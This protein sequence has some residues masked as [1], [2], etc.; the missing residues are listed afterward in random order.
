MATL[1]VTQDR[2]RTDV[3][4]WLIA[5]TV[6]LATFMEVLDTSVANVALPHIAG[7]LS[8]GVDEST[9]V[10]TSYLVS[11][12]IVLPLTGWLSNVFGRKQFY[13]AC[14]AIFTISSFLCGLAPSLGALVFFR[15]IQGAGGGGLQPISQAILVDSFPREKQGMAMAIYGMGVVVAP[16]IGPTLG[17]WITDNFTWR[18]I[19]FI[20]IPIGILSILLTTLLITNPPYA[21]K[22]RLRIDFIGI[23]L[24]SV[25]VGF[26]QIVL[27]KGQ[28]DDWFGSN[29]IVWATVIAL[30][31][32]VGVIVWELKQ[33]DPI[34]DLHLLKERNF[35]VAVF[36]MYILGFV[37][38][39]TTVL[40]PILLQTL[41]G[42][43]AMQSGLVLLPGG[44]LMMVAMP[45]VGWAL[46]KFEARWLVVIGLTITASG[47]FMM[48]SH[49]DLQM[50]EKTP[51]L[52]WIVSRFGVAFL[53]VPIN[54]I[55]FYYVLP[56]KINDATGLINLA[57]NIG[58]SMGISFVT[59]LLDR[60]AQSNQ[61]ILAAHI[62]GTNYQYQ[63][64]IQ[65]MVQHF[66]QAG[67]SAAAALQLA[68]RTFYATLQGQAM[69]LS[70]LRDFRIMGWISLGMIPFMFILKRARPGRRRAT[71]IH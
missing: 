71:P 26:L 23:G 70:F 55:A 41:L 53:F 42:Y 29:F 20:N 47:L 63:A 1:S 11:N 14:V 59:T 35:A 58:G 18:W 54:V 6:M 43:T 50:G 15:V 10:L 34:I 68:Q 25:G 39:G 7:S 13:M 64:A 33:K 9:W 37:L 28:R 3:N 52:V 2:P 56:Q 27:D 12:A 40:L 30:I 61:S 36:T 32:I 21:I 62:T 31:G 8:A 4:P 49:F 65:A 44:A 45:F 22:K 57:R 67:E 16:T 38:Y 60:G 51:V 46:G 19:F 48:G 69:M 24:L 66:M 5:A 17:G